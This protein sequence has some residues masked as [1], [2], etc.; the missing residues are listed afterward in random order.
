MNLLEEIV[1]KI[2]KDYGGYF[3]CEDNRADMYVYIDGNEE[4]I[5]AISTEQI[6]FE[7]DYHTVNLIDAD[8]HHLV[9]INKCI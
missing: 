7:D 2:V 1:V 9:Y 5:E 3:N 8:I 4:K 6:L